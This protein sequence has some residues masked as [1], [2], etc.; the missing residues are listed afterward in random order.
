MS[1][2]SNALEMAG[3]LDCQPGKCRNIQHADYIISCV[4]KESLQA[5]KVVFKTKCG[6]AARITD[7][8]GR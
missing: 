6:N 3:N 4:T 8:F 1:I 7:K 2:Q 5:I